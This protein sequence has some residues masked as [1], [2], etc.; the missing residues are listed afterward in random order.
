M[1]FKLV[2]LVNKV[3]IKFSQDGDNDGIS[4]PMRFRTSDR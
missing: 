1:I 2:R 3:F 4:V